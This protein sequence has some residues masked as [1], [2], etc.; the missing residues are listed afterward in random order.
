MLKRARVVLLLIICFF[1]SS[2]HFFEKET[3]SIEPSYAS[4]FEVVERTTSPL[5]EANKKWE[6]WA[7][8]YISVLEING[9]F[10]MWYEAY[11]SPFKDDKSSN[12]CYAYSTDGVN[13][14]KPVLNLKLTDKYQRNN[15][16]IN[17][18]DNGGAHA[19]FVFKDNGKLRMIFK[20]GS[21]LYTG[22]SDEGKEWEQIE[23]F[24]DYPSDTQSNVIKEE[25][26]Y[27]IYVRYRYKNKPKER[28]AGLTSLKAFNNPTLKGVIPILDAGN[29][30]GYDIYNPGVMKLN[31]SLY[32][33]MPS[34]FDYDKDSLIPGLAVSRDGRNFTFSPK[35]NFLK[36]GDDFDRKMIIISPN[37]IYDKIKEGYWVYY[38]GTKYGHDQRLKYA[39]KYMGGVGRFLLKVNKGN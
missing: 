29:I 27:K 21:A 38:M 2:C 31:D 36:L 33:A 23:A 17:G 14:E 10:H 7:I 16:V 24:W 11:A 35:F 26:H 6:S 25:G 34:K 30:E 22:V 5:L 39:N 9:K 1:F 20:R 13:W 15:I 8:N 37:V 18:E 3:R 19:P 12:I 4:R 32:I 28:L